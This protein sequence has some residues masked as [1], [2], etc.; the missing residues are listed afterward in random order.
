MTE[1][2][3]TLDG[4]DGGIEVGKAWSVWGLTDA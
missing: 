2:V 4:A 1:H 3:L